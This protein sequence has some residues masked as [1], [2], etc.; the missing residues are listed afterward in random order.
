MNHLLG[1]QHDA[2]IIH[3]KAAA[4]TD[5][6]NYNEEGVDGPILNP[7]QPCWACIDCAWND[8]IWDQFLAEFKNIHFEGTEPDID[9]EKE[10]EG[11]FIRC[12]R[13]LKREVTKAQPQKGEGK[14]GAAG[15]L[16]NEKLRKL[17]R[18]R[19]N[20]RRGQVSDSEI[21]TERIPLTW[22]AVVHASERHNIGE[23]HRSTWKS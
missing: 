18:Q 16:K 4:L 21:L 9:T 14:V 20:S 3:V 8:E 5:I 11:M 15:R 12:L 17:T 23:C 6:E 10:I 1:I 13:A 7:M 22:I 19:P 2:D